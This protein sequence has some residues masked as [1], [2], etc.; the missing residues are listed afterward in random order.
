MTVEESMRR[1]CTDGERWAERDLE[2]PSLTHN[3]I[4]RLREE[5]THAHS[6]RVLGPQHERFAAYCL[7]AARGYRLVAM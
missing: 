7:G 3:E 5:A 1:G 2:T 4:A 6:K